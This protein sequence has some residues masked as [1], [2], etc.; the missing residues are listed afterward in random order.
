[1]N[2]IQKAYS[3]K[4]EALADKRQVRVV[5][6]TSDVDRTGEIIVPDGI[7]WKAYMATGAGPVLWN[8]NANMPVAK[9]IEIERAGSG[10]TAL[11][12]FPPEGEDAESDK[13]YGRVKFGSVPGVSIGFRPVESEALD[14]GN[15][16]K[17]PQRYTVCDM[18]EFSFTPVPC[19]PSA[20][21]VD[22]SAK[23]SNWK[24]GASRNLSLDE[25]ADWDS[26]AAAKSIFDFADFDS[27]S[28]DAT[29]A[30]KGF[31]VYDAGAP[32]LR[33]A[34]KLPFAKIIDGRL[35]AVKAGI[36]AA[37]SE[38]PNSLTPEDAA[39]KARAVIDHYEA[40][41][42]KTSTPTLV[43]AGAKIEVKSLYNVSELARI[44]SN[45]AWLDDCMEWDALYNDDSVVVPGLLGGALQ[46]LGEALISMTE[47][48]VAALLKE[49]VSEETKTLTKGICADGAAPIVKV[50]IATHI[51]A[52]RRFSAASI[53]NMQE[54][55]KAIKEGHDTLQS[56]MDEQETSDTGETEKS[57]EADRAKALEATKQKRLREIEVLRL[58][59]P[60]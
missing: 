5:V 11:V 17:G 48:E 54:A 39:A 22:K 31:L 24:V 35:V 8:H 55:C 45:L 13:V 2:L 29:F 4:S 1:M 46:A 40:K 42:E 59:Q 9:C 25:V 28:P 38:L 7:N 18:M 19:N 15:P 10:I 14:K 16:T 6:S 57:A 21:V 32:D 58:A 20:L 51:K 26:E 23:G 60:L 53:S 33:S 49:E 52:G 41:M 12:Q 34:Y 27:D 36:R 56:M 50:M 30:R 43:K 44:L 47:A 3:A 37:A